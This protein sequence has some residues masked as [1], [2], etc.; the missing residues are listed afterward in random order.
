M[1]TPR[2]RVIKG[3]VWEW[4]KRTRGSIGNLAVTTLFT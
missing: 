4:D 1:V 3:M 2:L